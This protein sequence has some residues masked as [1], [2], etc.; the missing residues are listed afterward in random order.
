MA[1]PLSGVGQQQQIPLT[2]AL[3]PISSDQTRVTR[4][5]NEQARDNQIQARS[6]EAAS[7]Q[8]SNRTSTQ[9]QSARV[10]LTGNQ[11][12]QSNLQDRGSV[13]DITV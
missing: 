13:I 4:Q 2:Q 9:A 10:E 5:E 6:A 11:P 1:A 3:Q 12:Q 8:D 7:A